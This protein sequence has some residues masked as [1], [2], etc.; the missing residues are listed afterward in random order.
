M[1]DMLINEGLDFQSCSS[2]SQK[3]SRSLC[4][5]LQRIHQLRQHQHSSPS[6]SPHSSPSPSPPPPSP[7]LL[8]EIDTIYGVEKRLVPSLPN[9]L[10]N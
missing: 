10:H 2:L 3:K 1:K 7:S 5:Q 8:D 6:P 4:I 9:P